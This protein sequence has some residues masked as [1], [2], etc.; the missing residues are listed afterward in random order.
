M[1]V[2]SVVGAR[3]QFIK[4]SPM[5]RALVA[6]GH[7]HV[8]I[9]TGQHYDHGLSGAFFPELG[10]PPP[11]VNLGVGSG[12]PGRQTADALAGIETTL[13]D[14]KPEVA[15]VYGDTNS[16][17]AGALAAAKLHVPVAHVEAGARSHNRRMSE[18]VNRVLADHVSD[19][20]FALIGG[21]R[22]NLLCEGIDD[23]RIVVAGDVMYDAALLFRP[24][25]SEAGAILQRHGVQP[26][27]YVLGTV[28]RAENTD[29]PSR[30][31]AIFEGLAA[32]GAS[33]PVLLPIHPRTAQAMAAQGIGRSNS[34]G[35]GLHIIEPV[36]YRD[37]LALAANA[38]VIATDSGGLQREG[39]Y[40]RVPVVVIRDE[41]ETPELVELG[42]NEVCPPRSAQNLAESIL[43]ACG[44]VGREADL[45]GNGKASLVIVDALNN[46]YGAR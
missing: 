39:F 33:L 32:V 19:L 2:A 46:T 10:L 14:V 45:Y 5:H 11:D 20:L 35:A 3:P 4:L 36:G 16:T 21:D 30:L 17:L 28:H 44:R 38:L 24:S 31:A 6:A 18:E 27:A 41:T 43:G 12:S 25:S 9:H 8:I 26:R 40:H 7:H 42:W 15:L 34:A 13:R 23:F 22:D 29:V 37:M 1:R